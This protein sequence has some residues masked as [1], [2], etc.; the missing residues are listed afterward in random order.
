MNIVWI[1][2]QIQQIRME[3]DSEMDGIQ[4]GFKY[5]KSR[6]PNKIHLKSAQVA[7]GQQQALPVE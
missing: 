4:N 6:I 5:I 3:L 7:V 2:V 1:Y